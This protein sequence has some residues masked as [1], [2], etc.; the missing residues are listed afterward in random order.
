MTVTMT[1]TITTALMVSCFVGHTTLETSCFTCLRKSA[2]LV[3]IYII[4]SIEIKK[5]LFA[6]HT[7]PPPERNRRPTRATIFCYFLQITDTTNAQRRRALRF[8]S[9]DEDF[10]TFLEIVR[11]YILVIGY[12]VRPVNSNIDKKYHN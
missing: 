2:G 9:Y 6:S 1:K 5:L 11:Y 4:Y 10:P 3:F 8:R 12:N 7:A